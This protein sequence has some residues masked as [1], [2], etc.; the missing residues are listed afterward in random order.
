MTHYLKNVLKALLGRRSQP[1]VRVIYPQH[2]NSH[3]Y[4][5]EGEDLILKELLDSLD[6]GFY[7]DVGAHDPLKLSNT[8]LF[9]NIGWTGINIDP[10]P[11]MKASF[12]QIRPRDVNLEIGITNAPGELEL[13][14]FEEEALN[15]FDAKLA[16][17]RAAEG[18]YKPQQKTTAPVSRLRDILNQYAN[19][20]KITFMSIDVEGLEK[21][22]L[23]SNDWEKF[24]P[25]WLL[26]EL[27]DLDLESLNAHELHSYIVK[28]GYKLEAK[29]SR[30]AFYR[31]LRNA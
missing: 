31:N 10:I 14:R 12:D 19:D 6:P 15:T 28:L 22:I 26:I 1:E 16:A 9:Y 13:Y 5:Q 4:S 21:E 3:S 17:Q 23:D 7:V 2:S 29:T 24:R 18:K 30:T 25:Q 11:G 20:K 8:Q 27:I